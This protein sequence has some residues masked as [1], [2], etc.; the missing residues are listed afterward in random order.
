[1][2]NRLFQGIINQMREVLDRTIGVVDESGT[3]I[4]CSELGQIGE[5]RKGIISAGVFSGAQ[6][7]VIRFPVQFILDVGKVCE[8]EIEP[9]P[10]SPETRVLATLVH[11]AMNGIAEYFCFP[12]F[13]FALF[14]LKMDFLYFGVNRIGL[15]GLFRLGEEGKG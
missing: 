15:T 4:A 12:D 1:M 14:L 8:P 13:S 7:H 11:P 2:P 10:V 5:A 3:V 6:I 9:A